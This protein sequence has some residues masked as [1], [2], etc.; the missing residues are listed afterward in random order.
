MF[1]GSAQ[2]DEIA[3][4]L[5]G[6]V[7]AP[8]EFAAKYGMLEEEANSFREPHPHLSRP[9]HASH[10]QG[11]SNKGKHM[12][13]AAADVC[14]GICGSGVD[15]AGHRVQGTGRQCRKELGHIAGAGPEHG[16]D[17]EALVWMLRSDRSAGRGNTNS[18]GW[19]IGDS[20][21]E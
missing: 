19:I 20:H 12:A 16:R 9:R 21:G 11:R 4:L 2:A 15:T 5:C 17:W 3:D 10:S 6:K 7:M 18:L 1:R 14:L 13:R 8:K